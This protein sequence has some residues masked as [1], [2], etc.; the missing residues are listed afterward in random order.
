MVALTFSDYFRTNC[1]L[2]LALLTIKIIPT[3]KKVGVVEKIWQ[4]SAC[5]AAGIA[6]INSDCGN[7][8]RV[9]HDLR[10]QQAECT[11]AEGNYER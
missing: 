8:V 6:P 5:Y 7:R 2:H 3:A 4:V 9:Y 11:T 10:I 1:C